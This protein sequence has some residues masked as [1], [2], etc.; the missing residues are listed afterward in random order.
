MARFVFAASLSLAACVYIGSKRGFIS[1]ETDSIANSITVANSSAP[2]NITAQPETLTPAVDEPTA[3]PS[4]GIESA[5][6]CFTKKIPIPDPMQR[7]VGSYY[8]SYIDFGQKWSAL[9]VCPPKNTTWTRQG[10]RFMNGTE[11]P[12][13]NTTAPTVELCATLAANE[14]AFVVEWVYHHLLLGVRRVNL[15]PSNTV[16]RDKLFK[17][18]D[19]AGLR[20][21]LFYVHNTTVDWGE[22][23]I[24]TGGNHVSLEKRYIAHCYRERLVHSDAVLHIDVD[25]F[26]FPG[27]YPDIPTLFAAELPIGLDELA[28]CV[29]Y[30]GYGPNPPITFD[31]PAGH[32][33][34]S[35]MKRT[36]HSGAFCSNS[37]TG[38]MSRCV[39]KPKVKVRFHAVHQLPLCCGCKGSPLIGTYLKK[40]APTPC[41]RPSYF[42]AHLQQ[43]D[44]ELDFYR[45]KKSAEIDSR[46]NA[47]QMYQDW[48]TMASQNDT[49]FQRY[50]DAA[51]TAIEERCFTETGPA[52]CPVHP[53]RQTLFF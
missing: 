26:V 18:R 28:M 39:K 47:L 2:S 32:P 35:M 12:P 34:A 10:E 27:V 33:K 24:A 23:Y 52:I 7:L 14:E 46:A 21:D 15:Y 36:T 19:A 29:R 20:P 9:P 43:R 51:L 42:V 11:T 37:K 17:A 50:G 31:P 22:D 49:R 44:F 3:I 40:V 38:G 53:P 48:H 5:K 30:V 41:C 25:E 1:R 8:Q 16:Q 4:F 6:T 45:K 13:E